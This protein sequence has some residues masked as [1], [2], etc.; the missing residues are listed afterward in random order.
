MRGASYQLKQQMKLDSHFCTE[1]HIVLIA[2]LERKGVTCLNR[3]GSFEITFT[4]KLMLE[5]YC[6]PAAETSKPLEQHSVHEAMEE[7]RLVFP[8]C[9]P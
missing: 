4:D 1:Y 8:L 3:T 7:I 2:S 5:L 6:N 9:S